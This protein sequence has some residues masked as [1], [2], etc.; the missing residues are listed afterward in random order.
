MADTD[1]FEVM[2]ATVCRKVISDTW[3]TTLTLRIKWV[4]ETLI[5]AERVTF[6][7]NRNYTAVF[8]R[9]RIL[10]LFW[11]KLIQSTTS[12]LVLLRLNLILSS[13]LSLG[14]SSVFV[15]LIYATKSF[16]CYPFFLT[17]SATCLSHLHLLIL[18]YQ[19][20]IAPHSNVIQ[21]RPFYF[22]SYCCNLLTFSTLQ[23]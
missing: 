15:L 7:R 2:M 16:R 5:F 14:V 20:S 9:A 22:P 17:M 13:Y 3:L 19:Q 8:K 21:H 11:I 1:W 10:F 12:D 4:D 6:Y 18:A 23:P